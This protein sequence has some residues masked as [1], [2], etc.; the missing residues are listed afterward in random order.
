MDGSVYF[1]HG[2]PMILKSEIL[3]GRDKL[4]PEDYT[5]EIS[6]NCDLLVEKLNV[7]RAAYGHPLIISS[8]YR[9]PA[10]NAGTP[11]AAQKS[12]HMFCLAADFKDIDGKFWNWCLANLDLL[13]A[14]GCYLENRCWTPS[15]THVQ[16]VPP[17]SRKRIF[18]P[19]KGL[20]PFPDLFDGRYDSRY[21]K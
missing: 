5:Q 17:A 16:I 13:A 15:W 11:N 18:T 9:P 7:L 1:F 6:N 19:Q 10:V 4:F 8:G 20:P 12:N 14:T 3:Q 21:D 2:C